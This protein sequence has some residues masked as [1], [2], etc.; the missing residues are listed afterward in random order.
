ML[1]DICPMPKSL[2]QPMVI[3]G[4]LAY[5]RFEQSSSQERS[6]LGKRVNAVDIMSDDRKMWGNSSG[7]VRVVMQREACALICIKDQG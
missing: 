3:H 5:H 1:I 7:E 2:R 6:F 4:L